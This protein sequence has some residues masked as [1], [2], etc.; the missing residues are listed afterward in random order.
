[1]CAAGD[2]NVASS[3]ARNLVHWLFHLMN[4]AAPVGYGKGETALEVYEDS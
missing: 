2:S 4:G 3:L 1:M